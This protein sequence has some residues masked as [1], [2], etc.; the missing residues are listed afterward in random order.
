MSKEHMRALQA[1]LAGLGHDPG[2]ADGLWGPKTASA[3]LSLH[4]A[5]GK[6][7]AA[8]APAAVSAQTMSMIYQGAARHPVREIVVHCS[9]TRPEWYQGLSLNA[10]RDEIRRWHLANGWSDIGYHWLIDR[11]GAILAGRA[12]TVIGAHVSGRNNGTIGICLIGGHGS[13]ASDRF[14]RHY[15]AQQDASLR[16]LIHAVSMR[17]QIQRVSAHH[18]YANKACPGFNLSQWL[19]GA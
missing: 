14:E 6:P 9:A 11:D 19:K 17:T 5:A 1:A 10:K 16:A 7:P 12:E 2:P 4:A 13:A 3:V 8:P 18:D 15:T